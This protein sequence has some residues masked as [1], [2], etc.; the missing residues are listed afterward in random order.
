MQKI[1]DFTYTNQKDG[2][3]QAL[4]QAFF[5][6]G[7]TPLR[8]SEDIPAATSLA[9]TTIAEVVGTCKIR[10]RWVSFIDLGRMLIPFFVCRRYCCKVELPR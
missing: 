4:E 5:D 7:S 1:D 6:K 9:V 10:R 3:R 8:L 2:R